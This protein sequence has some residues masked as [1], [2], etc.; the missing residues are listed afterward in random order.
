MLTVNN[1]A[2]TIAS[3]QSK[4]IKVKLL[5]NIQV[6]V[7]QNQNTLRACGLSKR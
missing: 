5:R 7:E 4:S 2:T 1:A 3:L 6:D